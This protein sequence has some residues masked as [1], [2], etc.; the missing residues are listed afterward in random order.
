MQPEIDVLGISLKT[1][2]IFFALNFIAWGALAHRRL[3]ELGKPVEWASEMVLLAIFGGL[4][5]ARGYYLLQSHADLSLGNVLSGAGL[6]WY[7]G[8]AGGVV[9]MLIW[10]RWRG[11]FELALLDLAG[12][13]LALGAASGPVRWPGT[14]SGGSAARFPATATTARPGTARGRWAIRTARSRPSPA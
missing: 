12:P 2:G 14:R 4:V 10:A 1:F 6:I 7:G 8:L 3:K 5:G 13:C 9:A 11:F